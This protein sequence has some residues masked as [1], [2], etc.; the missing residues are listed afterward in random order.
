MASL[1]VQEILGNEGL[2]GLEGLEGLNLR[3]SLSDS[4]RAAARV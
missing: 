4:F 3:Q 2:V 1:R